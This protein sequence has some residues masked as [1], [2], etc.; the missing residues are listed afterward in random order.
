MWSINEEAMTNEIIKYL[1][2]LKKH[3]SGNNQ[4]STD[5]D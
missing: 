1:T 2:S 4:T 5:V 3:Q